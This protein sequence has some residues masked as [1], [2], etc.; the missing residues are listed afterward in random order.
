MPNQTLTNKYAYKTNK[1]EEIIVERWEWMDG[2]KRKKRFNQ[3]QKTTGKFLPYQHDKITGNST[4]IVE[5]EKCVDHLANLDLTAITGVGGANAIKRTEWTGLANMSVLLWPDVG[6][7]GQKWTTTL[8]EILT[9]LNCKI[10]IIDLPPDKPDGWD[11]ADTDITE[12]KQ[13]I[14]NHQKP[15][16]PGVDLGMTIMVQPKQKPEFKG[17]N[18]ITDRE[19]FERFKRLP[20]AQPKTGGFW[21][22]CCPAHD[23]KTPSLQFDYKDDKLSVKCYAGCSFEQILEAANVKNTPQPKKSRKKEQKLELPKDKPL[24][25]FKKM[26]TFKP[27][28]TEWLIDEWLALEDL[29]LIAGVPGIG[30]TT[31]TMKLAALVSTGGKWG[32]GSNVDKGEVL[33]YT[34]EDTIERAILRNMIANKADLDKISIAEH[35]YDP[36]IKDY[37]KFH[38]G[39]HLPQLEAELT[40][41][42]NVKLI[43]ID[44]ILS[45]AS[46][47]KDEYRATMIREKLEPLNDLAKKHKVAILGITHFMKR[48]N[49]KGA[50]YLDLII[51]SQAWGAVARAAWVVERV[52]DKKVI[53]RI[54][55]NDGPDYGGFE[56]EMNETHI[57]EGEKSLKASS[58]EYGEV[59]E[60]RIEELMQLHNEEDTEKGSKTNEAIIFLRQVFKNSHEPL[61]WETIVTE[62][63]K[64]GQIA[65][66]TLRVARSKLK[67]EIEPFKDGTGWM[68]RKK[69]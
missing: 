5:G 44:P 59:V 26:S 17:T 18:I 62:G 22:A 37:T 51:G 23:D 52:E 34:N 32:D 38:P 19:Q 29:T 9:E 3:T 39:Q 20:N 35:A 16:K 55:A 31:L 8:T 6:Q 10:S 2:D 68:W 54:K 14:I 65:E 60:G 13:L 48:H 61:A 46:G 28:E 56:F 30:K 63:K 57:V 27:R 15:Y 47:I 33:F 53:M 21:M 67:T 11:C 7:A 41:H 49:A 69:E 36:E 1:G 64:A 66:G 45:V 42:P 24:I 58:V 4:I 40:N 12:I 25:K 43:I 50:S